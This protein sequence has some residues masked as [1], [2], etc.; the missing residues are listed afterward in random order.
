[1]KANQILIRVLEDLGVTHIF[2]YPGGANLPIYDALYSSKKI[3]HI[4]AMHEQGAAL[5]AD[6]YARI[7]ND[8]GVCLATSGPGVTNIITGLANSYLDSVPIVALTGQIPM[9]FVGTDAFQEVDAINISLSVTKHNELVTNAKDIACIVREAFEIAGSGRKGPVLLD[10]PKDVLL[11][12]SRYKKNKRELLGYQPH[13]KAHIG[14]LKRCIKILKNSKKPL[15]LI[16]GGVERAQAISIVKKFAELINIPCVRTLMGKNSYSEDHPLFIG[17]IG[18]HGTVAGNKAI[19]QADVILALATRF[20]DRSTLMKKEKFAKQA[21]IIHVDIDPAEIGKIVPVKIPIVSDVHSFLTDII[22]LVKKK[23][24]KKEPWITKKPSK[25]ILPKED[26]APVIGEI[27]EK[28]SAINQKLHITTDV[29]RH[30]LWAIHNCQNPLHLPLLTSGGLGAM[31]FGLPAAIGAW[32][33]DPKTPV[34]NIAGD[35]SFFMNSQEFLVAVQY[36][37]PLTVLII[38]D[39]KLSMIRELQTSAYQK[40]YIGYDLKD[41]KVDFIGFARSLGGIGYQVQKMSE[42]TPTL[43]KAIANKKPTII[44]CYLEKIIKNYD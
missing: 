32:F 37:I 43:K 38:N 28:L 44:D 18:T 10:F 8:I 9:K 23:P 31:G 39:A 34:V 25:N 3:K 19:T 2:G 15:L 17:M 40:R 7:K 13:C 36:N 35:G 4:L 20:G 5:M 22:A 24:W 21:E 30:Q 41:R 27:I 11:E 12:E 1:M 16:G 42:V 6:G 29:G 26:G 33:A 14:Q